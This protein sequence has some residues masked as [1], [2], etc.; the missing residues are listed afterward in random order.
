MNLDIK[1]LKS[2]LPRL[3]DLY[4]W[5]GKL[6]YLPAKSCRAISV[7]WLVSLHLENTKTWCPPA[8]T[9]RYTYKYQGRGAEA[10]FLELE[11]EIKKA[12]P[13]KNSGFTPKRIPNINWIKDSLMYLWKGEDRF[14]FLLDTPINYNYTLDERKFM[15]GEGELKVS[16]A[17]YFLLLLKY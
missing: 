9:I 3:D 7:Q 4:T 12:V 13:A 5:S 14:G 10:L 11:K 16:S 6:F 15:A 17:Y 1:E 2:R 8:T